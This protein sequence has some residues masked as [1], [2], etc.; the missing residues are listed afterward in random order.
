MSSYPPPSV[1]LTSDNDITAPWYEYF[2]DRDLK[3]RNKIS[4]VSSGTTSNTIIENNG[5]TLVQTTPASTNTLALPDPG[6]TKTII[7]TST[8]T[9]GKVISASTATTIKPGT[10]WVLN[11][12]SSAADKLIQ[13]VGITTLDWYITSNPG[14]ATVST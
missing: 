3:T 12:P 2:R 14:G 4:Y 6:C 9:T 5:V 1:A 10:G 13:L 7:I 8:S 11:F